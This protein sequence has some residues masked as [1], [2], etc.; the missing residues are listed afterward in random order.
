M[1][2]SAYVVWLG[3]IA[4]IDGDCH[5]G[6][7]TRELE[8][9]TCLPSNE[10]RNRGRGDAAIQERESRIDGHRLSSIDLRLDRVSQAWPMLEEHIIHAITALI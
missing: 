7:C 6:N 3:S 2:L 8:S 9:T 1:R 5:Q 4:V 10:L